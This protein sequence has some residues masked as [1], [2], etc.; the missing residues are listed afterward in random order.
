MGSLGQ[1]E[2]VQMGSRQETPVVLTVEKEKA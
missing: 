2:R 1:V